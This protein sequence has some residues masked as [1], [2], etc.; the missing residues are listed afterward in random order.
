MNLT[1]IK[2]LMKNMDENMTKDVIKQMFKILCVNH[3]IN[4]NSFI[5]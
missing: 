1:Y 5:K 4:T 2:K 3:K